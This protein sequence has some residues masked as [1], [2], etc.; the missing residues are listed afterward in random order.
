VC[1]DQVLDKPASSKRVPR[2]SAYYYRTRGG[3]VQDLVLTE[4]RV[5]SKA[6]Q[7]REGDV[8]CSL[9]SDTILTSMRF[10]QSGI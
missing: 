2:A 5:S 1:E 9:G 6:E 7:R 4:G 3:L 8:P 10:D